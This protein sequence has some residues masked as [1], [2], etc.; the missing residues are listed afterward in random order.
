MRSSNLNL[1][2]LAGSLML[3]GCEEKSDGKEGKSRTEHNLQL[4]QEKV[5]AWKAGT[6]SLFDLVS[7]RVQWTVAGTSPVSGTYNSKR[8]FMNQAVAPISARLNAPVK[9]TAAELTGQD[10]KVVILWQGTATTK[11]GKEYNNSYSWHMT[12]QNDSIIRVEAFLDT[13]VLHDL[14]QR[15]TDSTGKQQ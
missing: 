8:D 10:D 9:L 1:I 7:E 4:V 3:I 15:I 13:Y 11:D 2:L 5:D 14:L 6:G 12:L